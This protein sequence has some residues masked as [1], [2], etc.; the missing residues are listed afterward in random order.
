[1]ISV[2]LNALDEDVI[3]YLTRLWASK[4]KKS[5]IQSYTREQSENNQ[6]PQSLIQNLIDNNIIVNSEPSTQQTEETVEPVILELLNQQTEKTIDFVV[7]E[8]ETDEKVEPVANESV[9][10]LPKD[11]S[12]IINNFPE[13]ETNNKSKFKKQVKENLA[14]LRE[15]GFRVYHN[16]GLEEEVNL[17]PKTVTPQDI[18][19]VYA[20]KTTDKLYKNSLMKDISRCTIFPKYKQG[21]TTK[22]VNFRYL[23]NHHN[24]DRKSVV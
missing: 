3:N 6:S 14:K 15:V 13:M 4:S 7:M 10:N 1:M 17:I 9:N 2:K 11:D 18:N 8:L 22:P 20:F 19:K 24:T 21:D 5:N 16:I 12:E 23:V